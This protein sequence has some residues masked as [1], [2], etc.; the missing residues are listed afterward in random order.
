M[1]IGENLIDN[2]ITIF[3]KG[4]KMKS[5]INQIILALLI[6]TNN[7]VYS[8]QPEVLWNENCPPSVLGTEQ[9]IQ[10]LKNDFPESYRWFG[11]FLDSKDGEKITEPKEELKKE[12]LL[13]DKVFKEIFKSDVLP[14]ESIKDNILLI[15]V[16]NSNR[17]E[18]IIQFRAKTSKYIIKCIK[19]PYNMAIIVRLVSG[20]NINMVE[21]ASNIFNKRILPIKWESP[22]YFEKMKVDGEILKRIFW[23][24]RDEMRLDSK[25]KSYRISD[26]STLPRPELI[27]LGECLYS[28]VT[29]Y[30]DSKFAMFIINHGPRMLKEDAKG[31]PGS[32]GTGD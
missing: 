16:D 29:T 20:E 10:S 3:S 18:Q 2:Q 23:Y 28:T 17:K 22:F 26:F 6:A 30:S 13:S 11:Q 7:T 14:L 24:T 8:N 5:L 31:Y 19:R 15:T 9:Q 4:N 12:I 1:N 25:G 32:A 27:P 21:L